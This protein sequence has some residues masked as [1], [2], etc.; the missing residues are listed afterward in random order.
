[1]AVAAAAAALVAMTVKSL[2]LQHV[3]T[4]PDALADALCGWMFVCE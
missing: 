3:L 1:M 4:L 2:C